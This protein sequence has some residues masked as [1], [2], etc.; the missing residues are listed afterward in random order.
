[1]DKPI[2]GDEIP[3]VAKISNVGSMHVQPAIVDNAILLF[4]R[5]GEDVVILAYS[6][7]ESADANSF[8][9]SEPCLI[10]PPYGDMGFLLHPPAYA[11]RPYSICI[12]GLK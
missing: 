4:Q 5:F 3:Y 2:G 9:P 8:V 10:C 7:N 1:M 6:L 11:R 12:L